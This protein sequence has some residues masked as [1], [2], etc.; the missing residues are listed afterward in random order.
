MFPGWIPSTPY[1]RIKM[2]MDVVLIVTAQ[3]TSTVFSKFTQ[4]RCHLLLLEILKIK[5]ALKISF[6]ESLKNN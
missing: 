4:L 3:T 5:K 6:A 2:K 1:V